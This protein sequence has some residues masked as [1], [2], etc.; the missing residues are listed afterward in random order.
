MITVYFKYFLF[1]I[2]VSNLL[3]SHDLTYVN[4]KFHLMRDGVIYCLDVNAS[5]WVLE[6]ELPKGMGPSRMGH[7]VRARWDGEHLF[8]LT[9][10]EKSRDLFVERGMLSRG[11]DGSKRWFWQLPVP[12][13]PLSG[14]L[15][16]WGDSVLLDS[17][18]PSD[19]KGKVDRL[20]LV[21]KDLLT[22]SEKIMLDR[23]LPRVPGRRVVL[24]DGTAYVFY[25]EGQ[26]YRIRMQDGETEELTNSLWADVDL[27][28]YLDGIGGPTGRENP[29]IFG[30]PFPDREGRIVFPT[31]VDVPLTEEDI[32]SVWTKLNPQERSNTRE[33]GLYPGCKGP[34]GWKA[35]VHFLAFDPVRARWERVPR[36]RY[37]SLVVERD[38]HF[39]SESLK[40]MD[41]GTVYVFDGDS[42]RKS[43]PRLEA[44]LQEKT[45]GKDRET[46]APNPKKTLKR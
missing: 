17:R 18:I 1:I 20:N 24:I 35:Q 7:A 4:G 3:F 23:P 40:E 12:I 43:Q 26:V 33:R 19:S 14:L 29:V 36:E 45:V 30:L 16:G 28:L 42:I 44:V 39:V 10:S 32:Q 2:F 6:S 25:T 38:L 37:M 27:V 5:E 13:P 11:G 34:V 8:R 15:V 22:G 9:H 31:V 21:Y 41:E 46:P